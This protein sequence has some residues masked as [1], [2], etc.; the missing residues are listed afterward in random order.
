VTDP[1]V[2]DYVRSMLPAPPAHVL[3]VGAG[4]GGLAEVMR[5]AGYDVLAVDPAATAPGVERLALLDVEAPAGSFDAAVA[6][7]SLHHVDPLAESCA[8]LAQLVRPGG[9]LVVDEFETER[10]DARAAGWW[11]ANHA[12]HPHPGETVAALRGH[13]HPVGDIREALGSWFTL[14]PVTRGP[15]LYRFQL[16]EAMR[17]EEERL[18]AEGRL[19]ATGAR[20]T[21][22]RADA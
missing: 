19:P 21:A 1:H 16:S 15:Y 13:L 6:V 14:S 12:E 11:S 17:P 8:H 22:T 3:E 20:F 2:V 10:F 4:D 7:V 5:G 9:L 18:I